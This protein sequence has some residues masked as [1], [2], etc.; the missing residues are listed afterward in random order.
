MSQIE[1]RREAAG[2]KPGW[3]MG[4]EGLTSVLRVLLPEAFDKIVK[5]SDG[6]NESTTTPSNTQHSDH[7]GHGTQKDAHSNH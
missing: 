2:M 6:F 7:K 4:L 1:G 3:S 5:S